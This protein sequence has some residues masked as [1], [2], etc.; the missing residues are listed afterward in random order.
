MIASL[1][2]VKPCS[3]SAIKQMS[4]VQ[5]EMTKVKDEVSAEAQVYNNCAIL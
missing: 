5:G 3:L 4:G 1:S 2:K